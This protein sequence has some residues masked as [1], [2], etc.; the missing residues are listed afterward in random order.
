MSIQDMKLY[1]INFSAFGLNIDMI[2]KIVLLTITILY[3][4]HKW[5]LMYEKNK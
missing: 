1:I 2:L 3:T 4:A 5:Y